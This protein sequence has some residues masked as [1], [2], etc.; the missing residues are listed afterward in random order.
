MQT[1]KGM[2]TKTT[3]KYAL[4]LFVVLF[5]STTAK[6]QYTTVSGT[7]TDTSSQAWASGTY[8]FAFFPGQSTGPFY[9]AG[10]PF[11]PTAFTGTLDGSGSFSGVSVPDNR[12]ISPGGTQWYVT[13]CPQAS[14]ACFTKNVTITGASMSV[15]A[16]VVPPPPIVQ[17]NA[18]TLPM[19]YSDSEIAGAVV[20][21]TYFNTTSSE[22][23]VCTV[24]VPC[25]WATVSG[26]GGVNPGTQ[27]LLPLYPSTG[28]VVGP[29]N[30]TTDSTKNNLNVPGITVITGPS[31]WLDIAAPGYGARAGQVS[32]TASCNGTTTIALTS[33]VAFVNGDGVTIYGC[34]PSSGLA[35][36]PSPT[37]GTYQSQ[38]ETT[39]LLY[40]VADTAG[41]STYSYLLIAYDKNGGKSIAGSPTTITNGPA[42]LGAHTFSVASASLTGSAL[43]VTASS[44]SNI[45][46][47]VLFHFWNST[48]AKMS[49]MFTTASVSSPSFTASGTANYS[50]GTTT[51]TGGSAT[52]MEGNSLSWTP[53][54]TWAVWEYGICA[55]R[56]GDSSYHLIGFTAPSVNNNAAPS[57]FFTD[58]GP[59]ITTPPTL[60]DYAS[61]A[62]CTAASPTP[63]HLS[64]TIVSGAGTTTL[65]VANAASQTAS[66]QTIHMDAAVG[67]NAAI[68]AAGSTK[69]VLIP[70]GKIF[71]TYSQIVDPNGKLG[72]WQQGELV[73]GATMV[74]KS[75]D[76]L[77][78]LA[79]QG[80]SDQFATTSAPIISTAGG[81]FPAIFENGGAD[82]IDKISFVASGNQA[83]FIDT[84]YVA[85]WDTFNRISFNTGGSSD[86]SGMCILIQGGEYEYNFNDINIDGGPGQV[87]GGYMDTT[88]TPEIWFT[89]DA[90]GVGEWYAN[91]I[92]TDNRGIY[93]V[94]NGIGVTGEINNFYSQG[95]ITPLYASFNGASGNA[96]Y[97][98]DVANASTDTTPEAAVATW[99]IPGTS[100]VDLRL[101]ISGNNLPSSSETGGVPNWITGVAPVSVD[102]TNQTS[103]LSLQ[104]QATLPLFVGCGGATHFSIEG[105]EVT[106][107]PIYE[108]PSGGSLFSVYPALLASL[109][110]TS[111]SSDNVTV[112]GMTSTGHCSVTATNSSAATNIATT[113]VSAKT[114][115][116][117]TVTHTT[118]SG[119]TYDITCWP[120]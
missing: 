52:Y 40:G 70:G 46:P 96:G 21:S 67:I 98:L 90:G 111:A 94:S 58:W 82:T 9:L 43:T 56:P 16:L 77:T 50:S 103:C 81:A 32:G 5:L 8:R 53:D 104:A 13:V 107:Y 14:S 6:A 15:S 51:S 71:Y 73:L 84:S 113:Y 76:N 66:S 27:Y 105:D 17:A 26:S 114:T 80:T 99:I 79:V 87:G 91:R 47:A 57:Q 28:S 100:S 23:R 68:A 22:M 117:I 120:N 37:V 45:L 119:M 78:S 108:S 38:G 106:T 93:Q 48:N 44:A 12:R 1:E 89:G 69:L 88:W 41:S 74:L 2:L 31:P 72:I 109:T 65:T 25:T 11:T 7:I 61:N 10:S 55:E 110:T 115:N 92:S 49:G 34:G 29:S 39:S 36:P 18:Q 54:H 30:I 64:T 19:A 24:S 83:L 86:Y 112:T 35:T 33:A 97:T 59:T 20:G 42:T 95:S 116:Q 102:A 118:T 3:I 85:G 60:P 62:D 75:Y 101:K 63:D 4:F